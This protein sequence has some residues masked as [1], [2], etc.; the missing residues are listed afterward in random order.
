MLTSKLYVINSASLAQ[1]AFR[2]KNLSFD[3][4]TLEFAQRML[5]IS[6]ESMVPIRFP[7]DDKTP[8]FLAE[9]VKELHGAMAEKHLGKMNASALQRVANTVNEIGTTFETESLYLWLRNM[10]TVATSDALFG[11]RN[12]LRRDQSLVDAIW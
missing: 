12:P 3:P 7:G 4:F 6:N 1:S 2:H 8:S 5:A 9:F 10:M 11:S